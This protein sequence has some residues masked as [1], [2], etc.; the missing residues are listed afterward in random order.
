MPPCIL[1]HQRSN[2][3]SCQVLA[4]GKF[5]VT[6]SLNI[7]GWVGLQLYRH[8]LLGVELCSRQRA[9]NVPPDAELQT[10]SFKS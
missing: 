3:D 7:A 5:K 2:E 10:L 6:V 4:L 8:V 9:L 1:R